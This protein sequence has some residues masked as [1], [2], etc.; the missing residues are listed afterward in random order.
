MFEEAHENLEGLRRL[1]AGQTSPAEA[2]RVAAHLTG[3]REC[4]LLASR[5]IAGQKASGGIAV[6]GTLRPLIDLHELEQARLEEWLEA[7]ATWTEVQS[8]STKARKDKVRLARSLHTLSFLEVL[9]EEGA[10]AS[11]AE[12]EECFYLA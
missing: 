4:W 9:F 1:F 5:V 2:E 3:C 10:S 12:S 6:P 7:Q 8:L 11:P